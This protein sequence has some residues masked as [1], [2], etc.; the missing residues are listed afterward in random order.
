[1]NLL[2]QPLL[3]AVELIIS[4]T[5]ACLSP[6]ESGLLSRSEAGIGP[7]RASRTLAAVLGCYAVLGLW[8]YAVLGL[9]CLQLRWCCMYR[10]VA[11]GHIVL[12]LLA[13]VL[14]GEASCQLVAGKRHPLIT[15]CWLVF[16][17]ADT[18]LGYKLVGNKRWMLCICR[19]SSGKT[20]VYMCGGLGCSSACMV[21]VAVPVA[22]AGGC[23][24]MPAAALDPHML[25]Q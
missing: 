1:M 20:C 2:Q 19:S 9:W 13:F 3:H 25:Q 24:A 7:K 8:C 21:A 4:A 12:Q 14:H 22:A 16:C 5:G 15:A 6:R 11:H 23:T 10:K 17:V 18:C